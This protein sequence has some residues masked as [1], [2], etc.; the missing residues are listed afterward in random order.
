MDTDDLPPPQQP[1]FDDTSFTGQLGLAFAG[2][3]WVA[4]FDAIAGAVLWAAIHW[5]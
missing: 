1:E 2:L 3:V 4:I 5:S